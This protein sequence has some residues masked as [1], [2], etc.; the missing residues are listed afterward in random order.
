MTPAPVMQRFKAN[1]ASLMSDFHRA[2]LEM[3]WLRLCRI[4]NASTEIENCDS[5]LNREL[6]WLWNSVYICRSSDYSITSKQVMVVNG[7]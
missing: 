7:E 1:E 4:T 2:T 6:R 3:A 5:S